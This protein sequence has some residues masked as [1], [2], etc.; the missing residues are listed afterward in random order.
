VAHEKQLGIYAQCSLFSPMFQFQN[1]DD[2]RNAAQAALQ[3]LLTPPKLS[4]RDLLRGNISR[5]YSNF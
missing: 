3:A 4:R 1:Q 2:A 5:Q